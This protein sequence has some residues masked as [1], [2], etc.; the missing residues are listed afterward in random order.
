M[1]WELITAQVFGKSS[2]KE[3]RHQN[4]LKENLDILWEVTNGES[5]E[6]ITFAESLLAYEPEDRPMARDVERQCGALRMKLGGQLLRDWSEITVG[7]LL[8]AKRNPLEDDPNSPTMMIGSGSNRSIADILEELELDPDKNDDE[9]HLAGQAAMSKWMP[10]TQD[11]YAPKGA[12]ATEFEL[13][14]L[15][16]QKGSSPGRPWWLIPGGVAA[17]LLM[18]S[19]GAWWAL[20]APGRGVLPP[21]AR[22]VASLERV[23][24]EASPTPTVPPDNEAPAVS[25][26]EVL[27]THK[28]LTGKMLDDYLTT[29]FDN[30]M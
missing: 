15:D 29:Y 17:V 2:S 20:T 28:G 12:G 21:P 8:A 3:I 18:L 25:D 27:A 24:P 26:A 22:P 9:T 10:P 5:E 23:K 7:P 11:F 13:G 6:L 14:E 1:L 16:G 19:V 4:R 30:G